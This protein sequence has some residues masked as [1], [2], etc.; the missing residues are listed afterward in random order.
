MKLL[1]GDLE[2]GT[3]ALFRGRTRLIPRE[4]PIECYIMQGEHPLPENVVEKFAKTGGELC[5]NVFLLSEYCNFAL[6]SGRLNTGSGKSGIITTAHGLRIACLGGIYDSDIYSSAEA[7]PVS[8]IVDT[9]SWSLICLIG[10]S[11][12][13][14]QSPHYGTPS[15]QHTHKVYD[16][17]KLQITSCYTVHGILLTTRRRFNNQCLAFLDYP[18]FLRSSTCP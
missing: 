6:L 10:I 9:N 5:K 3:I 1:S 17:P 8:L 4:A 2:G 16:Q 13:F 14:F 18:I 7:A 11:V 12:T 15:L